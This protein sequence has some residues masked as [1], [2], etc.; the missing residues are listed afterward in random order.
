[1]LAKNKHDFPTELLL[2]FYYYCEWFWV[3]SICPPKNQSASAVICPWPKQFS[4]NVQRQ[5]GWHSSANTRALEQPE[6]PCL[7]RATSTEQIERSIHQPFF[8]LTYHCRQQMVTLCFFCFQW[9]FL[10][11][12]WGGSFSVSMF[13]FAQWGKFQYCSRFFSNYHVTIFLFS[14]SQFS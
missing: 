2:F 10:C 11:L 9:F 5:T 8:L 14:N 1:M 13:Y 3:S 4:K 12:L 7:S 6:N